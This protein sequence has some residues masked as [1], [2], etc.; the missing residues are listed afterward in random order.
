MPLMSG[1]RKLLDASNDAATTAPV[2]SVEGE[3]V[4][5][6]S[7]PGA[8]LFL[9]G[10]GLAAVDTLHPC[11]GPAEVPAVIAEV[12]RCVRRGRHHRSR[13]RSGEVLPGQ[14]A[15]GVL[16]QVPQRLG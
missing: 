10:L 1:A 14:V 2:M 12:H 13:R 6:D 4:V 8:F 15:T 11:A 7:V 3:V 5:A 9:V 16:Q